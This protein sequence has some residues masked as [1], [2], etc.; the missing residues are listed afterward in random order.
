MSKFY[1]I[2]KKE[3]NK[4]NFVE[5]V[6]DKE[7]NKK[8]EITK[9][10]H[11]LYSENN[12][13]GIKFPNIT[14]CSYFFSF[15][16]NRDGQYV[17]VKDETIKNSNMSLPP[18]VKEG[19]IIMDT[20]KV[21]DFS[22]FLKS[23]SSKLIEFTPNIDYSSAKDMRYA[24]AYLSSLEKIHDINSKNCKIFIGTF[25]ECRN[26]K[27]VNIDTTSGTT[28]TDMFNR[29]LKLKRISLKTEN[30]EDFIRCFELCS[31]LTNV[32]LSNLN[33]GK[34]FNVMFGGCSSLK[35]INLKNETKRGT[36]FDSMFEKCSSLEKIEG[37]DV[38]S[39]VVGEYWTQ[40]YPKFYN[41]FDGCFSLKTLDM[42]NI[43][44]TLNLKD[45]SLLTEESILN[46]SKELCSVPDDFK[47]HDRIYITFNDNDR[48]KNYLNNTYCRVIDS[49]DSKKP[50]ELAEKDTDSAISLADYI[51]DEKGWGLYYASASNN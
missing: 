44:K 1:S 46:I 42:K 17:S 41:T 15:D 38:Q 18:Y 13:L 37:L 33:N 27:E 8:G 25:C 48:I 6:N 47:G 31:S 50:I 16:K 36:S 40:A 34:N 4:Y 45:S 3:K 29:C 12:M 10:S 2:I 22:Y 24:F 30:V 26:L 19:S 7:Y 11:G 32:S 28:M 14:S 39:A 20:S 43:K 23:N 49:T 51:K 35:E 5:K 9:T 21:E